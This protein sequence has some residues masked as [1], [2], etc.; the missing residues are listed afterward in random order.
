MFF[1]CEPLGTST[2]VDC[3]LRDSSRYIFSSKRKGKEN[4]YVSQLSVCRQSVVERTSPASVLLSSRAFCSW[5]LLSPDEIWPIEREKLR[6]DGSQILTLVA[7]KAA[8]E[9]WGIPASRCL[10]KFVWEMAIL[11]IVFGAITLWSPHVVHVTH[12]KIPLRIP[13]IDFFFFFQQSMIVFK[14][15]FSMMFFKAL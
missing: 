11:K 15:S 9:E 8:V 12:F 10:K 6:T 2:F 14:I 1:L 5:N 3:I 13:C 4:C 7:Y